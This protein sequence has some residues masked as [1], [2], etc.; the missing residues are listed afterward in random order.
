MKVR[1][2]VRGKAR[3]YGNVLDY[4]RPNGKEDA[5]LNLNKSSAYQEPSRTASAKQHYLRQSRYLPGIST[6]KN[7]AIN[8]S[9]DFAGS[10]LWGNSSIPFGGT[11][12]S[13]GAHGT[14][15]IPGG[16]MPSFYKKDTGSAGHRGPQGPSVE[17]TA[18]NYATWQ[19]GRSP[20]NTSTN[21]PSPNKSTPGL[22]PR[23][24]TQTIHG[25]TDWSAKYGHR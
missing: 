8:A 9:K 7:V 3:R 19:S 18:S 12:P 5:P 16:Y 23:P 21:V 6:T 15:T 13:R 14:N 17:S 1:M 25:R 20:M 10:H 24:P 22:L 4:S 11:L 2:S